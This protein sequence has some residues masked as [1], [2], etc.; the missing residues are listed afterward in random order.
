MPGDLI[1]L[2]RYKLG[3]EKDW[4]RERQQQDRDRLRGAA[5]RAAIDI[6]D[7]GEKPSLRALAKAAG[8]NATTIRNWFSP[9]YLDKY[10]DQLQKVRARNAKHDIEW[11]KGLFASPVAGR[12]QEC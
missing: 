1:V 5:L 7:R 11:V 9:G 8:V 4:K 12:A 2:I 6:M 10:Y 3:S